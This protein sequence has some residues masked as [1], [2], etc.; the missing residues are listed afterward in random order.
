MRYNASPA[1]R[2]RNVKKNMV[3]VQRLR[4]FFPDNRDSLTKAGAPA[5]VDSP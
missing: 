3:V 2:T 5:H 4:D 1:K